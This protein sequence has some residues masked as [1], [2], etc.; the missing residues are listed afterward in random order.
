MCG[1]TPDCRMRNLAETLP[2]CN[3]VR[4]LG[5]E[6]FCCVSSEFAGVLKQ[7]SERSV[8]VDFHPGL[9]NETGQQIGEVRQDHRVAVTSGDEHRVIDRA[10]SLQRCVIRDAPVAHRVILCLSGRPGGR[11]IDIAG[12]SVYASQYRLPCFSTRSRRGEKDIEIT[13]RV[14]LGL[15]HC[16]DYLGG[17]AMHS[18]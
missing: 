16:A 7:E 6:E 2:T 11:F 14:W 12:A 18:G 1:G 3:S 13:V 5:V 17:P 15:A 10:E 9:G 4:G 8:G